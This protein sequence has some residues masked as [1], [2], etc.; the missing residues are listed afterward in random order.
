VKAPARD[1]PLARTE[2][3][4]SANSSV[5]LFRQHTPA[6]IP[7]CL[8]GRWPEGPEGVE[9]HHST[10]PTHARQASSGAAVR[11]RCPRLPHVWDECCAVPRPPGCRKIEVRRACGTGRR[12]SAAH[13][14]HPVVSRLPVWIAASCHTP[15]HR[16][17]IIP[18]LLAGEV[19]RRPGGGGWSSSAHPARQSGIRVPRPRGTRRKI[20]AHHALFQVVACGR[21]RVERRLGWCGRSA[22]HG[23]YAWSAPTCGRA[24][25][26]RCALKGRFAVTAQ[27]CQLNNRLA[28][29][30][31]PL[32]HLP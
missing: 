29:S 17:G 8:R 12:V 19:G 5:A 32:S 22:L 23:P 18:P 6:D 2:E 7:P 10:Q 24:A 31:P 9:S 30:P 26:V 1:W 14:R 13:N 21:R 27:A 28:A 11:S 15:I 3:T 4:L 16:Q 20:A 25:A